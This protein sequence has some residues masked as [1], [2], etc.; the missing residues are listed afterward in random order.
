MHLIRRKLGA[1]GKI[2]WYN[3]GSGTFTFKTRDNC[4][5]HKALSTYYQAPKMFIFSCFQ[6]M[7]N[8]T[9]GENYIIFLALFYRILNVGLYLLL[10]EWK[11]TDFLAIFRKRRIHWMKFV[12]VFDGQSLSITMKSWYHRNPTFLPQDFSWIKK[13]GKKITIHIYKK[14][15]L[16]RQKMWIWKMWIWKMWIWKMWNWKMWI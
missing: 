16:N 5:I 2:S 10:R 7:G 15:D 14:I 9:S 8:S 6:L 3:S 11:L 1:R 12:D 13:T 4:T